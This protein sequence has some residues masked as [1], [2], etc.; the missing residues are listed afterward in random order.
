MKNAALVALVFALVFAVPLWCDVV[1][2][3]QDARQPKDQTP[4][5]KDNAL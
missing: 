3:Y 5:R 2:A 1:R 4:S